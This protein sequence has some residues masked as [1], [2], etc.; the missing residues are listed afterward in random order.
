MK[1]KLKKWMGAMLFTM[2]L[3]AMGQQH[4]YQNPEL[5][6]EQRAADLLTRL[7]LEEKVALMQNASP[8]IPRLGIKAYDWWNEALHGVGRSGTATVFP[9]TIGMAASFND[10]LLYDVFTAVSD[11]ARAKYV[12]A[13]KQGD[14]KRYQGLTFWTPNVNI[15]RDPRW[16]RGQETYGEDPYL[17]SRMGTAVVRG[18]QGPEETKYDKLHACAKHFAVHSGPEWNRHEFNA[19]NIAPRDLWETYMPAFKTL[20]QKAHVK[21]VM[22]AYNRWEGEPCCGNNRL[23]TQI[24][25]ND[26]GFEGIVVSDCGAISD[27]WHKGDH[28]THPDQKHASAGA[29]L[30]GT[31]LE[32]G[33][34]Y[35]SLPEAVKAGLIDEEQINTSV[36]RLLKARFEL[37]EM[38]ENVCWDTIPHSVV[39]CQAHKDLALEIAR[40]SIVLLQNRN[41][42]LPLKKGMKIALIGPNAADSVTHWGNYNGYPSHTETL[43]EALKKRLPA[44]Q[45]IYDF[46]CDRTASVTL[47]SVF[48]QCAID[49]KPGFKSTYWNNIKLEG[50]PAAVTQSPTPFHFTTLGATVFAPGVNI[51]DF[52]ARYESVFTAEKTEDIKFQFS[53]HGIIHLY[54]DGKKVATGKN[55]QNHATLYTLKAKQGQ[56]YD[57]KFEFIFANRDRAAQLD[58][59]MGRDIPV[60]LQATVEKVKDAD[61]ILFAGGISPT[62]EGEEMPVDAEGFK[63]GDRTS[64]ELPAIQR[65]LVAELKKTGKPIVFINYSGSAMGLTPESEICDGMLQVWYPGQ[66]GGT[67]IADVLLGDYNPAGRLPVTFYTHTGQLPDFEDYSMK[68]RTYRYLTEKPLFPFGYGLSYTTF[69]YGEAQLSKN[70]FSQGETLTLTIPVTNT[71]DRDGEEVVQVYLRRPGDADAPSHTLRAFQRVHINKGETQ[72]VI[73]SLSDENFLWFNPDTNDMNLVKGEYEL[74][75]GGT[76]D[77]NALHTI[78]LTIL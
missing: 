58:F 67:A 76:S 69:G 25:R 55:L 4:P 35:R 62:L 68:G 41:D 57:V 72:K 74:L 44:S 49:G 19:E 39:D 48:G 40:E 17:T 53:A 6:A 38:D 73:L 1:K 51:H 14:L 2:A 22:C 30:S 7:T 42:I 29:V 54:I 63:G 15:F 34:N 16:G 50:T 3:P 60:N 37:G 21:E 12:Q 77:T 66:A 11:E 13:R 70:T 52:S 18:L 31:D 27:F 33:N 47:E 23:L 9:Q 61:I 10:D 78:R 45:L 46:G 36:K 75:Y 64:I 5:T 20:V 32:C 28:E 43:Y 8:A 59:D 56:S 71:G 24:L 65:Q 26:W